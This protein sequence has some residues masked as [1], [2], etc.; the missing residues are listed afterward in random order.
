ACYTFGS[1]KVGNDEYD[2]QIKVP[3]Y[4]VINDVDI[5]P[6]F[7]PPKGVIQVLCKFLS[8]KKKISAILNKIN[9]YEHN[10]PGHQLTECDDT[11][12][13]LQII[14]DPGEPMRFYKMIGD[15]FRRKKGFDIGIKCHALDG[16]K[17]YREKLAHWAMWRKNIGKIK[18]T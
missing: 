4:R 11:F 17:G 13:K 10:G 5:V 7:P 16:A 18:A 1:P 3:I 9:G 14:P 15:I 2:D 6:L 8:K 12:K